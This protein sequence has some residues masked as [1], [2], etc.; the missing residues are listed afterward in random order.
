[1]FQRCRPELRCLKVLGGSVFRC[2]SRFY[3]IS[4][5]QTE[6]MHKY[7]YHPNKWRYDA[8]KKRAIDSDDFD[9]Y[10]A[11]DHFHESD[12]YKFQ[13]AV[14]AHRNYA[15]DKFSALYEQARL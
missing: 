6:E 2:D 7:Q 4:K 12:W 8:I 10:W 9:K 13:K 1:V 11:K 3:H 15:L 5:A 14:E